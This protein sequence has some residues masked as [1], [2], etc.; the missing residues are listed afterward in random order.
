MKI[1]WNKGK[2]LTEAHKSNISKSLTGRIAWNKDKELSA[3]HKE[4]IAKAM[5]SKREMIVQ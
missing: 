3:A 5:R 2:K 4:K 1:A